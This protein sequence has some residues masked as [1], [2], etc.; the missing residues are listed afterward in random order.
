MEQS[1]V[2]KRQCDELSAVD[3]HLL[4]KQAVEIWDHPQLPVDI[5]LE[6]DSVEG[7]KYL[8][9]GLDKGIDYSKLLIDLS[10]NN[11][12]NKIERNLNNGN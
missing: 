10:K 2:R 1:E 3:S 12:L 5:L 8:E 11:Q 7:C 9:S 6:I 4:Q